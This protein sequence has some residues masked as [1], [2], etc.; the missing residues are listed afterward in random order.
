MILSPFNELQSDA[1]LRELIYHFKKASIQD[2]KAPEA[3]I[4]FESYL[5]HEMFQISTLEDIDKLRTTAE[6]VVK[7]EYIL[8]REK[9]KMHIVNQYVDAAIVELE[10]EK[11]E[12]RVMRQKYENLLS[13]ERDL[14]K[15]KQEQDEKTTKFHNMI[16]NFKDK[17]TKVFDNFQ[18][19]MQIKKGNLRY[20]IKFRTSYERS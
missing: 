17:V 7:L 19:I 5:R 16:V 15:Y 6:R 11:E 8:L 20:V 10:S 13:M 14:Q 18:E 9:S 3:D 12:Y 1:K 4:E 2:I